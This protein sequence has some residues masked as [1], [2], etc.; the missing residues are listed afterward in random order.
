MKNNRRHQHKQNGGRTDSR[1]WGYRCQNFRDPRCWR[2][3]GSWIQIAESLMISVAF[4]FFRDQAC[5][6][7]Q[8]LWLHYPQWV[9]M[10]R[11]CVWR[12]AG[13]VVGS[14]GTSLSIASRTWLFAG[15][16]WMNLARSCGPGPPQILNR[17]TWSCS[18]AHQLKSSRY[19]WKFCSCVFTHFACCVGLL[20]F[21][22]YNRD[23]CIVQKRCKDEVWDQ[24][25]PNNLE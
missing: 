25:V 19:T 23:S 24:Q 4:L 18:A 21:L 2:K 22:Y 11:S 1:L 12:W 5:V 15:G 3:A 20:L 17:A 9:S 16:S 14:T 7:F 6:M 8:F 10:S 13:G